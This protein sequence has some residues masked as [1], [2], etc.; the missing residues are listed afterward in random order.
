MLLQNGH[1]L[2]L[3]E[4]TVN[5]LCHINVIS[6]G[7]PAPICSWLCFNCDGLGWTHS[8]TEFAS[9]ASF[10]TRRIPPQSVLTTKPWTQRAFLKWVIDG[11][12]LFEEVGQSDTKSWLEQHCWFKE[13]KK[14]VKRME[15]PRKISVS[16][17]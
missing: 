1:Q 10:L 6:C 4:S 3:T 11:C 9:N 5:T 15:I 17:K 2:Y 14:N 7:S 16:N 8:L 12:R 13:M